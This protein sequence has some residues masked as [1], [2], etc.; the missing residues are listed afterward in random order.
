VAQ[1]IGGT[2]HL[3]ETPMDSASE[4]GIL[5]HGE[6][7][8]AV[9]LNVGDIE[10][11]DDLEEL[12]GVYGPDEECEEETTTTTVPPETPDTTA[13]P[14]VSPT[15]VAPTPST[16][17]DIPDGDWPEPAQ[18]ESDGPSAAIILVSI[19]GGLALIGGAKRLFFSRS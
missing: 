12:D 9:I 19:A 13:P 4:S 15:T 8:F 2:G 17:M 5:P 14:S 6:Y 18:N 7:N 3:E 11:I 10:I 1:E 16:T